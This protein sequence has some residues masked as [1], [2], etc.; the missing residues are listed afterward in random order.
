MSE[1]SL[2]RRKKWRYFQGFAQAI[3]GP[4][5]RAAGPDTMKLPLGF[6]HEIH[7]LPAKSKHKDYSRDL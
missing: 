4:S 7:L 3:A 1:E 5:S 6:L 2:V